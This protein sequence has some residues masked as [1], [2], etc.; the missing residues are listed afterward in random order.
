MVW[1]YFRAEPTPLNPDETRILAPMPHVPR[2]GETVVFPN[3]DNTWPR[4]EIL[5]VEHFVHH[6][7]KEGDPPMAFDSEAEDDDDRFRL[8]EENMSVE[9]YVDIARLEDD[10][11]SP[12]R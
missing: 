9:V 11:S 3:R 2:V 1:V 12:I 6:F 4:F 5:K 7:R 8:D 10:A